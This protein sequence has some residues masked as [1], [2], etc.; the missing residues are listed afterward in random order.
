M[1]VRGYDSDTNRLNRVRIKA[2][3]SIEISIFFNGF[4]VILT[5]HNKQ[6]LMRNCSFDTISYFSHL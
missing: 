3:L 1:E 2:V 4:S 6:K 5:N